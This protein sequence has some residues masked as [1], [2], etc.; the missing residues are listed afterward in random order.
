[1]AFPI[2]LAYQLGRFDA[3]TWAGVKKAADFLIGLQQDG[4]NAPRTPAEWWENQSGY[5]PPTI[6][7]EI[8]GLVCAA[9]FARHNGRRLRHRAAEGG[10]PAVPVYGRHQ[11]IGRQWI[12]QGRSA[13]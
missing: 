12:R 9:T 4:N 1:M 3:G 13:R 11:G 10:Q 2:V 5:S 8:A 7:S 6:A